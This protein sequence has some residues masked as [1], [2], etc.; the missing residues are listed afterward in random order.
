MTIPAFAEAQVALKGCKGL[1]VGIAN[2][3]SIAW[4]CA[5]AFRGLGAELAVTLTVQVQVRARELA[6]ISQCLRHGH[7]H[8]G[9]LP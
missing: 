1:I 6:T 5:K 3:Q 9:D 7:S 8:K 4:G 2:E